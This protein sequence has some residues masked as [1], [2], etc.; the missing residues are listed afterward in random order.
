MNLQGKELVAV[1]GCYTVLLVVSYRR[2]G[3]EYP[4]HHEGWSRPGCPQTSVF[5]NK[6][7][8]TSWKS[9]NLK[10]TGINLKSRLQGNICCLMWP[11]NF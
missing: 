11:E 5:N 7:R 6:R 9:G 4:S 1:I 8:V 3:R 2:F 10:Y